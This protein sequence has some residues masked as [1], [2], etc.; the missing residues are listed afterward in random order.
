MF[1]SIFYLTIHNYSEL[2]VTTNNLVMCSW[3]WSGRLCILTKFRPYTIV[4]GA[5]HLELRICWPCMLAVSGRALC[6][7]LVP[8]RAVSWN[9]TFSESSYSSFKCGE[10]KQR[11][12]RNAFHFWNGSSL[13]EFVRRAVKQNTI[14]AALTHLASVRMFNTL[15]NRRDGW[16]AG[17]SRAKML[18]PTF[19]GLSRR[20]IVR[21]R[22]TSWA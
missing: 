21:R 14:V 5:S 7:L 22:C 20:G 11:N 2:S 10:L 4:I 15:P 18:Q 13:L 8:P 1:Y 19:A 6:P 12:K 16:S 3:H 17:G 9:G